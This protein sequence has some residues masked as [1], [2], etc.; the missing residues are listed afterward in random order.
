MFKGATLS[1]RAWSPLEGS[2]RRQKIWLTLHHV[3]LHAW[4]LA[5]FGRI[6]ESFGYLISIRW[7]SLETLLLGSILLLVEVLEPKCIPPWVWIEVDNL[8]YPISIV[9]RKFGLPKRRHRWNPHDHFP[10]TR[11]YRPFFLASQRSSDHRSSLRALR[12]TLPSISGNDGDGAVRKS[13][14]KACVGPTLLEPSSEGGVVN[15]Y[16][17]PLGPSASS[18]HRPGKEVVEDLHSPGSSVFVENQLSLGTNTVE[19]GTPAALTSIPAATRQA[20]LN[21][22]ALRSLELTTHNFVPTSITAAVGGT[23]SS[24]PLPPGLLSLQLPG[25]S[26]NAVFPSTFPYLDDPPGSSASSLSTTPCRS[27]L[28]CSED[29]SS[30][31]QS[32]DSSPSLP[33][34]PP[35]ILSLTFLPLPF[36]YHCDPSLF[37]SSVLMEVDP[38]LI[39]YGII[40]VHSLHPSPPDLAHL[41]ELL[42]PYLPQPALLISLGKITMVL[43]PY[44]FSPSSPINF[45]PQ[46]FP[47]HF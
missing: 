46:P 15:S 18:T 4:S 25:G 42:G 32:A 36:F 5:T 7:K 39:P 14:S 30:I 40:T 13:A 44:E 37:A 26:P 21:P 24:L 8:F 20:P 16:H 10:G 29:A 41:S 9:S 17:L 38:S 12:D 6:A 28:R 34:V 23:L 2:F 27:S 22:C 11:V 47:Y 31:V 19:I 3:P 43:F 1:L 35:S 45:G 33:H